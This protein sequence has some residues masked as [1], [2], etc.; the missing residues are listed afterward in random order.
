MS[1]LSAEVKAALE[2]WN[3]GTAHYDDAKWVDKHIRSGKEQ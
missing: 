3:N 2:R 1:E